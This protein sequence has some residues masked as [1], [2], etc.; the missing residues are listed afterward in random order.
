MLQNRGLS[1]EYRGFVV[2][3]LNTHFVLRVPLHNYIGAW[4]WQSLG[5]RDMSVEYEAVGATCQCYHISGLPPIYIYCLEGLACQRSPA[6]GW[7][8]V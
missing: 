7:G 4:A 5:H 2:A 8:I 3:A 6:H 1:V